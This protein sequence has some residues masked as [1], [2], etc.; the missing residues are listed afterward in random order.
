MVVSN[1]TYDDAI[2]HTHLRVVLL[3]L[4]T[5]RDN[6]KVGVRY[7]GKPG[8]IGAILKVYLLLLTLIAHATLIIRI[9][10]LLHVIVSVLNLFVHDHH[11]GATTIANVLGFGIAHRREH[12]SDQITTST[13]AERFENVL[14][15]SA[16][17][18]RIYMELRAISASFLARLLGFGERETPPT[19]CDV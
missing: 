3:D 1:A 13:C 10:A 5:H 17:A 2:T 6:S 11:F 16:V 7:L 4:K 8:P 14:V 19:V 9:G 12:K 18:R 15:G